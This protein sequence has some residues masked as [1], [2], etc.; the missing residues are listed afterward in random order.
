MKTCIK[1]AS[2]LPLAGFYAHPKMADGHLNKCKECCKKDARG[3]YQKHRHL[4]AE[5]EHKRNRW[6]ERRKKQV[7]YLQR[8]RAKNPEKSYARNS[9]AWAVKTGKLKPEPC[10]VCGGFPAEAHHED[11]SRP[12]DVKWLCRKHHWQLHMRAATQR[13]GAGGTRFPPS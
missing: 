11:Y 10:E 6:P 7:E 5:Y 13:N 4:Y 9:V 3:N 2:L 8:H 1:C 12:L